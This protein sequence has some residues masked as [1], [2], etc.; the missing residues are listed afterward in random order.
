MDLKSLDVRPSQLERARELAIR[1]L[2]CYQ[3]F[4]FSDTFATGA[5]YEFAHVAE[6]AGMVY[7]PDISPAMLEN[8]S[9]R[10]H[11]IDSSLK[12]PFLEY[13]GRLAALYDSF[14]DAIESHVGP[15][16]DLTMADIGCCSGYFPVAFSKRG[17]K[18]AVGFDVVDYT[19]TF[20]LLNEILGTNAEFQNRGYDPKLGGI[21]GAG[22][23]DVVV[24]IAV[25]VHLS[26]PLHHLAFLGATARKAILVW[27]WTSE[28]PEEMAIRYGSINR[29]YADAKFPYCFDIM[30]I[31]PALL[32]T[33]LELMGFDEVHEITNRPD[34]MP[35]Y[36]FD[37]HRGY[38]AVRRGDDRS[39]EAADSA[40]T[41]PQT[42][43][44]AP[45][46]GR[47]PVLDRVRRLLGK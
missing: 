12:E 46:P 40:A 25:L 41:H 11:V 2:M 34:G 30:Q 15:F 13:R 19:D 38:L 16:N 28:D 4:E 39:V 17:A 20:T 45:G 47:G 27:T 5:G 1:G 21:D 42:A 10:R 22:T 18:R 14:I 23:F 35:D 8:P 33:S 9:I 6:G 31:S 32:R 24:S 43:G 37:R 3:P 36:W 7:Y 26:D 44:T 29:Y